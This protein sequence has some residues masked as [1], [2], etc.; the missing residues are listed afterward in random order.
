MKW[1]NKPNKKVVFSQSLES[2]NERKNI[3]IKKEKLKKKERK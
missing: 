1:K 2:R 3:Q